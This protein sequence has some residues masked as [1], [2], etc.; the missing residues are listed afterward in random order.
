MGRERIKPL[1][2]RK[3][4]RWFR[5]PAVEQD[6]ALI[7]PSDEIAEADQVRDPRE[8]V[9]MDGHE[10]T[11]WN[12]GVNNPYPLIFKKQIVEGRC[13]D[14]RVQRLGPP[15][16]FP[17]R[18]K[19]RLV[20]RCPPGP[21]IQRL[22]RSWGTAP[23]STRKRNVSST[24]QTS[25]HLPAAKSMNVDSRCSD[26]LPRSSNP[27]KL[28]AVGAMERESMRNLLTVR[29]DVIDLNAHIG[30]SLQQVVVMV[31]QSGNAGPD[32]AGKAMVNHR[33]AVHLQ[34]SFQIPRLES[35][36]GTLEHVDIF[37]S[38]HEP[39]PMLHYSVRAGLALQS[40]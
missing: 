39:P 22:V 27:Q 4:A 20:H 15:P 10:R 5:L 36:A 2:R 6:L 32:A 40:S 17:G 25:M 1:C 7:I 34:M 26:R 35:Q 21:I 24:C 12:V 28:T 8:T 30:E 23:I 16:G 37:L 18:R 13:G 33:A 38:R 29:N 31:T 19:G 11:R 14:E 9:R 3:F